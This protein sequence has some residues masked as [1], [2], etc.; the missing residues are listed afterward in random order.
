MIFIGIDVASNKHDCTITDQHGTVLEDS[1]TIKNDYQGFSLL[2][3][4]IEKHKGN[5]QV[6]AGL[7]STG[8]YGNNLISYLVER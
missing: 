5:H 8:H 7:E 2:S 6:Y 4:R 3:Q 1:F